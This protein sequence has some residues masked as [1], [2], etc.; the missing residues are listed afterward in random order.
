MID[1]DMRLKERIEKNILNRSKTFRNVVSAISCHTGNIFFFYILFSTIPFEQ[2]IFQKEIE[3][4]YCGFVVFI[5][6]CL[7]RCACLLILLC[8]SRKPQFSVEK[9]VF[10]YSRIN[11]M[12]LG[13][14]DKF[15]K[16]IAA[17][18]RL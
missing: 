2:L 3:F 4:F 15:L 9:N 17:Y 6:A 18:A 7:R 8:P 11:A 14:L 13:D 10:L 1:N 12:R 16:E 5:F